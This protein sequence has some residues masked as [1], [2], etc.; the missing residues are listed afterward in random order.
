MS[1]I[2]NDIATKY[3]V[4]SAIAESGGGGSEYDAELYCYHSASS[5]DDYVFTIVKGSFAELAAKADEKIPPNILFRY[6]NDS[7]MKIGS[8]TLMP[9]YN[10]NLSG[11]V[12][13]IS[14]SINTEWPKVALL[15]W[16]A[17]D[18]VYFD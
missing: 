7:T 8:T 16:N 18:E 11:S 1:F 9:I 5:A 14:F 6:W 12:P 2:H 4:D 15:Y 10:I 3:S 17:N 13:Y